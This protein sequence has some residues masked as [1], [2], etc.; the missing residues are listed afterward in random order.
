MTHLSSAARPSAVASAPLGGSLIILEL[1]TRFDIALDGRIEREAA[2]DGGPGPL[3][4]LAGYDQGVIA[5]LGREVS[6]DIAEALNA[7]VADEPPLVTPD[8]VPRHLEH[9]LDLLGAQG[10]VALHAGLTF[11]L[12]R[13]T[14]APGAVQM[15]FS[16]TIEAAQLEERFAREGTPPPLAAMNIRKPA[17]L[18]PPYCLVIEDGEIASMAFAS[19]LG[20]R[21]AELGLE[22]LPPYRGRGLAAQAVAGWSA[23]PALTGRTLFYSTSHSNLASQRVVAKL[24]LP[25]VGPTWG[26]SR[27]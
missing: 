26:I 9:Y 24:G 15:I 1:E 12:P 17:D 18:W 11:H 27:S 23:H 8:D 3:M 7:L 22:T 19:R 13:G 10:D 14:R 21:G 2:P 20:P 5:R 25:F 4:F 16:G 6:D